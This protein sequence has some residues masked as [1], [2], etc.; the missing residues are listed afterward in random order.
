MPE[1]QLAGES[2]L[3]E[4]LRMCMELVLLTVFINGLG[5]KNRRETGDL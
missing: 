2:W 5:K 3:R 4:L 1:L